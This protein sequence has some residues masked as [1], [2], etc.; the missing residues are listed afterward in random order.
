MGTLKVRTTTGGWLDVTTAGPSGP[1]GVDGVDGAP[2]PTGPQGIAT[3]IVGQFVTR[4]SADLPVNGTIPADWDGVG[5]FP[6]G[7][8]M[9]QGQA[10]IDNN[11]ASASVGDLW[12]FAGAAV[13]AGWINVGQVV[14]P[15]GAAGVAGPT[16][17]T[18][19]AGTP[20][21]ARV[22]G[23][24]QSAS[25][26]TGTAVN[27]MAELLVLPAM[28]FYADRYYH[29]F[30]S[31]R[32]IQDP[33]V[34]ANVQVR[35]SVGTVNLQGYDVMSCTDP[36]QLWGAWSQNWLHLG[37]LLGAAAGGTSMNVRAAWQCSVASRTI[38]TPRLHV[39]EYGP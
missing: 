1:P 16:G 22:L 39:I 8:Q 15:A 11:P 4:T 26:V 33:G 17:P 38:Y 18:G 30:A 9:V 6:G 23:T 25:V 14:G 29:V 27:T 21:A 31:H 7:Y 37:S 19:P 13:A 12:Q 28:T 2:G 34:G 20:G 36:N 10:L 24:I 32:C 5:T 35:V 3:T